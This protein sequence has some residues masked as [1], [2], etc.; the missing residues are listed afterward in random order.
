[1]PSRGPY[2]LVFVLTLLHTSNMNK[3]LGKVLYQ[4]HRT[5]LWRT[6]R[7]SSQIIR[8]IFWWIVSALNLSHDF[9]SISLLFKLPLVRVCGSQNS[10]AYKAMGLIRLWKSCS[11]LLYGIFLL[12]YIR[13]LIPNQARE[14]FDTRDSTP[15]VTVPDGLSIN[16]KYLYS[17]TTSSLVF[18][19]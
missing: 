6:C 11:A 18:P 2:L 7:L 14:A 17:A 15:T 8:H 16:P 19:I 5:H 12:V 1:M 9:S 13:L 4:S 3:T 10:V